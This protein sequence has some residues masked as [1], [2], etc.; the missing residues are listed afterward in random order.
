MN[1]IMNKG[2]I[3]S[4]VAYIDVL[5]FKE[6]VM[7]N[8]FESIEGLFFDFNITP[9]LPLYDYKEILP[10]ESI[11]KITVNIISDSIVISIPKSVKFSL[12]ILISMVSSFTMNLLYLYGLLCRGG[13]ADG[14][15]YAKNNIAFGP[16]FISAYMLEKNVAIYPRIVFTRSTFDSYKMS[17]QSHDIER[18]KNLIKLDESDELYF[19]DYVRHSLYKTTINGT[20]PAFNESIYDKIRMCIEQ[21]I[22]Q[23]T[24]THVR[25]KYLYFKKYYNEVLF[26]AKKN[27]LLDFKCDFIFGEEYQNQANSYKLEQYNTSNNYS[28]NDIS[29]STNIAFGEKSIVKIEK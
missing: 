2:Y 15:F 1:N 7:K 19:V 26:E 22:V 17:C 28:N 23:R 8:D 20:E 9:N 27:N 25:A 13:I 3:D 16:A 4:Y 21:E 12:E 5:G 29:N 14:K 10:K 6:F 24:D 11:K 18:M